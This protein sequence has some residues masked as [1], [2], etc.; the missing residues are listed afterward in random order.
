MGKMRK[1][2]AEKTASVRSCEA[3]LSEAAKQA[4]PEKKSA[5]R[6]SIIDKLKKDRRGDPQDAPPEMSHA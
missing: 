6:R 5:A 1:A 4:S 3:E 2:I